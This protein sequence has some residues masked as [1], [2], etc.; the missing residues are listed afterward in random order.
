MA[1]PKRLCTDIQI[2]N[3]NFGGQMQF[4]EN[5]FHCSFLV[6]VS[7]FHLGPIMNVL[8]RFK[9]IMDDF[10]SRN[11]IFGSIYCSVN[12]FT[13]ALTVSVS[14]FT[15]LALTVERHKAG[16]TTDRR[17]AHCNGGAEF[18][19][20]WSSRQAIMTPLAPRKSHKTLWVGI[21]LVWAGGCLVALP[22]AV[23]ATI[24]TSNNR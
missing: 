21:G 1:K 18:G 17:A 12:S 10:V 16:Q 19:L 4:L 15:L 3:F 22:P 5:T 24:L 9:E 13:S 6:L 8:S 14:V 11:W 7:D 23:F 2:W 20:Q